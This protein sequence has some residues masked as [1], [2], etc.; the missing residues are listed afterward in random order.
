MDEKSG[1]FTDNIQRCGNLPAN[2]A[3]F[4]DMCELSSD[5]YL[6][7]RGP[8]S[9]MSSRMKWYEGASGGLYG[10][11]SMTK[12]AWEARTGNTLHPPH[13]R[14]T[15][16]CTTSYKHRFLHVH[17]KPLQAA[18]WRDAKHMGTIADFSKEQGKRASEPT[19]KPH[20]YAVYNHTS[21][22]YSHV[23]PLSP[24]T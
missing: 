21:E 14:T 13:K 7:F 22:P 8:C 23:R 24:L 10:S 19:L 4:L 5:V 9:G 20:E 17:S 6:D 12:D 11:Q 16:F 15:L 18:E 2:H 1:R 3:D